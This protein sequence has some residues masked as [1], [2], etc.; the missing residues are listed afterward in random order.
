MTNST[1]TT[2]TTPPV[3]TGYSTP[4]TK[5][6]A[7]PAATP[8]VETPAVAPVVVATPAVDENGYDIVPKVETPAVV[9]TPKVEEKKVENPSTGYDKP[10]EEVKKPEDKPAVEKTDEEKTAEETAAAQLKVDIDTALGEL[11]EEQRKAVGDFAIENNMTKEQ[12]AA[13]AKLELQSIA[14]DEA[15]VVTQRNAWKKELL[16]DKDFGG[17]NFDK[18]VDRVERLLE[19]HM[20]NTKKVLT[21]RGSMMPPYIMKDLL[22]VSKLLNPITPLINGEASTVVVESKGNFL[23]EMY[24]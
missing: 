3:A 22:A 11:P 23:D 19:T 5:M 20:V 17:D 1:T 8:V 12:V 16:D 2:E 14:D 6:P 18:S 24:G 21:E 9:E 4:E 10:V 13:Y 15:A 7:P